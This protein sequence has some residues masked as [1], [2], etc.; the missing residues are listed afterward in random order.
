MD[1][2]RI[3]DADGHVQERD[4]NWQELLE[5]PY[6]KHA[7]KMIA[8][9]DGKEQLLLEGKIWAKPSGTGLGIGTA[10]Y[11]RRHAGSPRPPGSTSRRTSW[12]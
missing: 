5:A 9:P 3:I 1:N 6:R 11:S 7:P 8:G 4:A 10:P 12:S 2:L